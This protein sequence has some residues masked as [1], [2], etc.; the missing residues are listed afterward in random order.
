MSASRWAHAAQPL[1]QAARQRQATRP[2]L[3]C[4]LALSVAR[5]WRPVV[6]TRLARTLGGTRQRHQSAYTHEYIPCIRSCL[7]LP[8]RPGPLNHGRKVGFLSNASGP[9]GSNQR[10]HRPSPASRPHTL[11]KLA[12]PHRSRLGSS[13]HLA[14]SR[15]RASKFCAAYVPS[16]CCGAVNARWR[17]TRLL[18]NKG[19]SSRLAWSSRGCC[20]HLARYRSIATCAGAA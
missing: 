15:I 19:A 12:C 13:G 2:A 6:V 5:A 9:T 14:A 18:W 3:Q 17:C 10:W 11:G 8:R 4:K 7:D 16:A 1:A 20:T